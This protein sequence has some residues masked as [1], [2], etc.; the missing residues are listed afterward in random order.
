MWA[1]RRKQR[2]TTNKTTILTSISTCMKNATWCNSGLTVQGKKNL[3]VYWLH[4]EMLTLLTVMDST[5]FCTVCYGWE[6]SSE[7]FSSL[8]CLP[9]LVDITLKTEATV[10]CRLKGMGTVSLSMSICFL[11]IYFNSSGSKAQY[12]ISGFHEDI[13]GDLPKRKAQV[14]DIVLCAASLRQVADVNN[15]T[16]CRFSLGKLEKKSHSKPCLHLKYSSH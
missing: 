7:R 10:W 6:I 14:N 13:V 2:T 3:T 12:L 1:A 5:S 15:S 8:P 11:P 9:A 4:F 16:Q